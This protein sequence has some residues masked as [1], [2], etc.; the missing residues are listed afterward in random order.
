MHDNSAVHTSRLVQ[1][2]FDANPDIQQ[3]PW[4]AKSLDL[5]PIENVWAHMKSSWISGQLRTKEA[6]RNHQV[7]QVWNQLALRPNYTQNLINSMG[8]RLQLV[9]NNDGYWI[10]Y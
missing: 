2:W 1:T 3:I 10:P 7:H 9:I 4:P 8:R 5:N 6:L